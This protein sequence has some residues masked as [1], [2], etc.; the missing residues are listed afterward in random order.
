VVGFDTTGNSQISLSLGSFGFDAP[1]G[2]VFDGSDIWVANAGGGVTEFDTGGNL[3]RLI[4]G[5]AGNAFGL[6]N[7]LR[8][9]F[10]G[11]HVWATDSSAVSEIATSH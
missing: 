4:S 5:A 8:I 3:V 7:P 9:A 11:S 6:N 1:D 10:D 2:M